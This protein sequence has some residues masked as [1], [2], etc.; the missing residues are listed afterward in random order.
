MFPHPPAWTRINLEVNGGVSGGLE[1]EQRSDGPQRRSPAGSSHASGTPSSRS[2]QLARARRAE[3]T[4]TE[5]Q[6]ERTPANTTPAATSP[7]TTVLRLRPA[8]GAVPAV[9]V[10]VLEPGAGAAAP[11]VDEAD[12]LHHR[13]RDAGAWDDGA[14]AQARPALL[15]V[16][17]E[18]VQG[19][20]RARV[21]QQPVPGLRE[22]GVQ[23]AEQQAAGQDLCGR[24]AIASCA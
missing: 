13:G 15:Q 23:G 9:S 6:C 5:R 22:A 2:E 1:R 18:R 3:R 10:S 19:Q 17:V 8:H 21:L 14:A 12:V 11:H 20:G 24:V 4:P 7:S 16:R